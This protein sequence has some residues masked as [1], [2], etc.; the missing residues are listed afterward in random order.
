[1][2]ARLQQLTSELVTGDP[3]QSE[4]FV[5]AVIDEKS[6]GRLEA[7]LAEAGATAEVVAGGTCDRSRGWFVDPTIV[8]V[9][10][11][12]HRLLREEL[13]GPILTCF[14]YDDADWDRVLR[15]VDDGSPYAL[16]GAIFAQD[17]TAIQQARDVLRYTAGNFYINDKP[18]GSVVGLQPF[19]GARASGTNDKVGTVWN[20]IRWLSPRATKAQHLPPTSWRYPHVEP[21]R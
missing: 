8:R 12:R 16:T 21:D 18:T 10:D 17:S 15:Q 2:K 3:T 5:G 13:F 7:A 4:T 20:T 19:G 1:L 11:P 14:V 9:D 6:F